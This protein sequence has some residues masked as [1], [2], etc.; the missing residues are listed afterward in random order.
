M[1]IFPVTT[2]LTH[3]NQ[4]KILQHCFDSPILHCSGAMMPGQ[5]GPTSLDLFCLSNLCFTRTISCCGIP[6]VMHTIS[7]I[8]ASIASRMAAAAAGGG[9]YITVA[10]APVAARA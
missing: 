10:S 7:G 9:T 4:L 6:S 1:R 5:L 3:L 8:S 2:I